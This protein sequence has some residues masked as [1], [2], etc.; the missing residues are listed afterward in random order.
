[1]LFQLA[2]SCIHA[3]LVFMCHCTDLFFPAFFLDYLLVS[4]GTT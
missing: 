2:M 3:I 4:N 1:M